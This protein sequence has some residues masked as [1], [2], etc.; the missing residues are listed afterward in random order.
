MN[1]YSFKTV[2]CSTS[3]GGRAGGLALLWNNCN[4]ELNI[5]SHDSNY[6]DFLIN[7]HNINWRA[8]DIYGYPN[9]IKKFQTCRLISDLSQINDNPNWLVFGDFNMCMSNNKKAGGN[10]MD[11]NTMTSFRN[12]IDICN[13]NDLGFEGP[14]FTWHNRQQ[15]D[16]YIQARLDRFFAN[17]NWV[18]I[19]PHYRNSHLLRYQYDH[20][21][22]LLEFSNHKLCR[23]N[24]FH[25]PSKKFEQ[26]WLREEEHY[27]I[28]QDS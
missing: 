12:T 7:Y 19:F 1:S 3:G 24:R 25:P 13:L 27:Q 14:K 6:I 16:H 4:F 28:V 23:Q 5:I 21:H 20:C 8:T 2:D 10:T 11:Y 26:M 22:I 9:Q 18:S 17:T 15:D